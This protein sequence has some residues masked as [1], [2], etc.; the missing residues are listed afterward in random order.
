MIE[1]LSDRVGNLTLNSNSYVVPSLSYYSL[2]IIPIL[3]SLCNDSLKKMSG[4]S[5]YEFTKSHFKTLVATV[6]ASSLFKR[7]VTEK[8]FALSED[9]MNL[10]ELKIV[11][12]ENDPVWNLKANDISKYNVKTPQQRNTKDYRF[13]DVALYVILPNYKELLVFNVNLEYINMNQLPVDTSANPF[14]PR[15][16]FN[17]SRKDTAEFKSGFYYKSRVLSEEFGQYF[18]KLSKLYG[19]KFFNVPISGYNGETNETIKFRDI[20]QNIY[21]EQ[22]LHWNDKKIMLQKELEY[23]NSK[24]AL[25]VKHVMLYGMVNTVY[26]N[27]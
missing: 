10:D 23:S 15:Y 19:G 8:M 6:A 22:E 12:I 4:N 27:Y 20:L 16:E 9:N 24:Y 21:D 7:L 11:V 14:H 2:D 13:T 25:D 5:L 17:T 1:D 26:K 18:N 3:M